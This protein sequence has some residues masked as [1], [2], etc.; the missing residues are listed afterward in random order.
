M[1]TFD[2]IGVQIPQVLLPSEGIDLKKWA[3]IACDQFTSQPDYWEEVK[4]FVGESPSTLHLVLPEVFLETQDV[5][6]RIKLIQQNMLDYVSGNVFQP[7]DDLIYVERF[8]SGKTR[9][10]ILLALDLEKYEFKPGS[11]SII[12]ASEATITERIP[13]RLQIRKGAV[14]DIPHILILIDDPECTVIEPLSQKKEQ[15]TKLYD[16]DLM[17]GSGHVRGY[18]VGTQ[19]V[20]E[21]TRALMNLADSK[22]FY[23]KYAVPEEKGILL[24][25]VG[26]GNHSMATA[27]TYWE[28]IK[29]H[30]SEQHPA[31]YILVE[32]VNLYDESLEFEPIHR[33]MFGLKE[34][35]TPLLKEYFSNKISKQQ[36][37]SR[38]EMALIVKKDG[39]VDNKH[40]IGLVC[41]D[42]ISILVIEDPKANLPVT[43]L[44]GFVDFVLNKNLVEKV[45][46]VHGDDV[47][48]E[49][50]EK[51][52]NAGFFIPTMDKAELFRTVILDGNLP[53]KAFSMGHAKDKRFYLECRKIT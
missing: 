14:L 34:D 47:V 19:S 16:F 41:R 46:Y 28:E 49:L 32:V 21:I 26:D 27:K 51:P 12:R 13:P 42:E 29:K 6:A 36:C 8:S 45:D 24:F 48:C 9:K 37:S 15:F 33:V 10:G 23:Q 50:G 4:E 2:D 31:R 25:A 22:I 30:V 17:M 20:N 18:G 40:R 7:T 11:Q 44:Q 1:R 3:V 5:A 53:K 39:S 52:G 38:D 43:T 35:I